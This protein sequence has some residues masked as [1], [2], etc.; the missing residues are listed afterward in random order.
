MQ[1]PFFVSHEVFK[2]AVDKKSMDKHVEEYQIRR[3]FPR[4][5]LNKS[6]G[7]LSRGHYFIAHS[8]DVGEGGLS[9]RTDMVLNEGSQVI[10]NFQI[11][12]G[13]FV[14]ARAEVRSTQKKEETG[15]V[16]HGLSFENISFSSKR[17]I[18]AYV[19]ARTGS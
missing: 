15:E 1:G 19:S 10:V 14:S 17:Q 18:R 7:I 3:K 9:I 4:K 6:V 13:G 2:R 11:P 12:G 5:E 8:T 16:V